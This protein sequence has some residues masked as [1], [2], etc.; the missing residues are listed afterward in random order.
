MGASRK[1]LLVTGVTSVLWRRRSARG[2][3][4]DTCTRDDH[5]PGVKMHLV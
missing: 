3:N 4:H 1:L 5:V 2:T